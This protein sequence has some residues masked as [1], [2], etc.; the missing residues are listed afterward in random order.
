MRNIFI[1]CKQKLLDDDDDDFRG[2][3]YKKTQWAINY[4]NYLMFLWTTFSEDYKKNFPRYKNQIRLNQLIFHP[5]YDNMNFIYV[6]LSE[7]TCKNI[8]ISVTETKIMETF[9]TIERCF[10]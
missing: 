1:T 7:D 6:S 2:N 10:V 4:Y 3:Y 8:R 9:N 5:C